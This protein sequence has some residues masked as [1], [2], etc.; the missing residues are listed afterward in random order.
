MLKLILQPAVMEEKME[1]S[2]GTIPY[3]IKGKEIYYLLIKTKNNGYCGFPKGHVE[4]NESE[5]ETASRETFEETSIRV[6]I[7]QE[8]RYE[9]A[10]K[11]NNGI[12]KT[13]VYYLASF[14][15]QSPKRNSNFEDFEY[16]LLPFDNARHALTFESTKKMLENVNEFLLANILK[17]SH[18]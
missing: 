12:N 14:Q 13:V 11:I 17:A 10:Y 2:C 18:L 15:D 4:N 16:L 6:V 5:L 7:N 1:K 9:I 8:F 3:T